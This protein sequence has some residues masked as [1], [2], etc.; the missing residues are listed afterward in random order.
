MQRFLIRLAHR[1]IA[2]ACVVWLALAVGACERE[3]EPPA[4]EPGEWR[5][6]EGSWNAAGTRRTIP[7]G[8]DRK[9]SI[10][11]LRGTMLLVGA[12][13]PG[14]G[15]QSEVIALVDSE[16]GL[17]GRGV[18][19]D[20]RGD[21][22]FSDLKGEGTKEKNHIVGTILGGTGRY[23]GATGTF[24]F[25]WQFVI[26]LEDGSIQGRAVNLKGRIRRGQPAAGG[27]T[28]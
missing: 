22:V 7:L 25:S 6:F 9:G 17:V 19:T 15:F 16:T 21:Q 13:R 4:L 8:T 2:G 5:E 1:A 14:V 26:E 27:A 28:Q 24:E 12:R 3:R 23:A 20:E 11:D 10:I 18:W